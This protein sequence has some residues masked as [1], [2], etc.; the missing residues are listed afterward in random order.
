MKVQVETVSSVER[1]VVIE[2]DAGEVA[3]E[4]ERAYKGLS[5]Q[6]KV[7]GFRA[8]K[9]PRR[10]LETRFRDQVEQDVVQHL[11]EH[12][13]K[14]AVDEQELFPVA[15]PVVS[16]ERLE[17]GKPF[18]YEARVEVKPEVILK[19]WEG[20]GYEPATGEVTDQ[21]VQ[22]ELLRLQ[23]SLSHMVPIED[24]KVAVTGDYA[25]IHYVGRREGTEFEGGK[26]EGVT[27]LVGP[28]S[29]LEG[30]APMLAGVEVGQTVEADVEFPPDYRD[31][32]LRGQTAQFAITLERIQKREVPELDDELAKDVGGDAKTLDE[33]KAKIRENLQTRENDRIERE[34]RER[35]LKALIEK[36]PVDVPKAMVERGIDVMMSGAVER[37]ARQGI[38]VRQ[39][40]LDFRRLREDLRER[41][42]DEVKSALLLEALAEAQ[43]L[44]ISDDELAD[45]YRKV[46]EGSGVPEAKVRAHYEKDASERSGLKVRLQEEKA[47]ALLKSRANV[48]T[49]A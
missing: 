18:R 36:N 19:E 48:K 8:G 1:K 24:R 45:H 11:V 30:N 7:P 15:P 44:E 40:G 43:K 38:D 16:P 47:L 10:I 3:R 37:F 12:S 29:L 27:V 34:N 28:G 46:A 9:V 22:D 32:A 6:V 20:L 14:D 21:M 13:W 35:L 49:L 31:E 33:L 25:L 17:E 23:D 4:L 26:G 2:V 39:L 42:T 41:A 5:R